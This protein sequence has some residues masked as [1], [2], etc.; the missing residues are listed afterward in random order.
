[1]NRRKFLAAS[2][3]AAAL[4]S[5]AR[6][7]KRAARYDEKQCPFCTTKPGVCSYCNGTKK[8]SFC[9][10]KGKRKTVSPNIPEENI[11]P[12]SYEEQCPYCKGSG[13][14]RYCR[15]SGICWACKGSG[16]VENWDFYEQSRQAKE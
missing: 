7:D 10:G 14:C 11:K 2:A 6:M 15:G 16:K 8:C 4:V 9:D 3:A 12:G 13:T 5:C 1:M